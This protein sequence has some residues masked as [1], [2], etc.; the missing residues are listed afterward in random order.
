VPFYLEHSGSPD[1]FHGVPFPSVGARVVID[2]H[3]PAARR[4][5]AVHRQL[6]SP[7]R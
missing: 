6:D 1:E 7:D 5:P 2:I 4:P 3:R